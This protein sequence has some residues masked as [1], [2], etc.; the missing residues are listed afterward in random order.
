MLNY[1]QLIFAVVEED[2]SNLPGGFPQP[3]LAEIYSSMDI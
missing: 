3:I 1:V 2:G